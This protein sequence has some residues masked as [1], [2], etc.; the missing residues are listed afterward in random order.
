[1]VKSTHDLPIIRCTCGYELLLLTDAQVMGQ[2]IENHVLEHKNKYG[3][4]QK[5]TESLEDNLIA[6]A[7]ELAEKKS[8]QP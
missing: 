3:L 6:Q 1:M 8:K 5:Q 4:T 7:F 2:A